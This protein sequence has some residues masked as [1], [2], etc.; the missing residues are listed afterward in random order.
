M[1]FI[2]SCLT[3]DDWESIPDTEIVKV[4]S[5]TSKCDLDHISTK[6]TEKFANLPP[7]RFA[8]I[9]GEDDVYSKNAFAGGESMNVL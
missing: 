1:D 5:Q 9:S 7:D 4:Q 3:R 8:N 6:L 2:K